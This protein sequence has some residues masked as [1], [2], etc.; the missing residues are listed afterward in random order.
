M[1]QKQVEE[2]K[3]ELDKRTALIQDLRAARRADEQQTVSLESGS[4]MLQEQLQAEKHKVSGMERELDE[5]RQTL[6]AGKR[7]IAAL[8]QQNRD[9]DV[10]VKVCR[11]QLTTQEEVCSVFLCFSFLTFCWRFIELDWIGFGKVD[12]SEKCGGGEEGGRVEGSTIYCRH[13]QV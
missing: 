12:Q 11:G 10:E 5:V 9:L 13:L 8:E 7:R 3:A 6:A 1:Q 4:H 2:A